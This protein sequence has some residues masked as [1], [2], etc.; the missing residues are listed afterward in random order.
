MF[1]SQPKQ[2]FSWEI[3]SQYLSLTHSVVQAILEVTEL[4]LPL[5][6]KY[7]S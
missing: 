7:S 1:V 5:P 6:P 2:T 3:R 4:C